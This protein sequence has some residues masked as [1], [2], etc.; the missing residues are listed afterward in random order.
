MVDVLNRAGIDSDTGPNG[1]Y[2]IDP[3]YKDEPLMDTLNRM[4]LFDDMKN[5]TKTDL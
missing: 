2:K 1:Q 5:D 4:G 3:D